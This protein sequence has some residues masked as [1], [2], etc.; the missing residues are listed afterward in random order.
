MSASQPAR[1][2]E[3][4]DESKTRKEENLSTKNQPRTHRRERRFE[5]GFFVRKI[6][7]GWVVFFKQFP[8]GDRARVLEELK[9]DAAQRQARPQGEPQ[10]MAMA[11]AGHR[12]PVDEQA[13]QTDGPGI[14][15]GDTGPVGST[16]ID[17]GVFAGTTETTNGY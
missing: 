6:V 7:N 4:D 9:R 1:L 14:G 10:I 12:D 3:Q 16:R 15:E 13:K 17:A 8:P 2:P 5:L 11:H